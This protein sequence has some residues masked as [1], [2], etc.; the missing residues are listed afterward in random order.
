MGKLDNLKISPTMVMATV[1]QEELNKLFYLDPDYDAELEMLKYQYDHEE[2]VRMGL[3]A[4]SVTGAGNKYCYREQIVNILYKEYF[5]AGKKIPSMIKNAFEY[6][7]KLDRS[8]PIHLAR[9][10]EEGKSIGTKWQRLFIRGKLGIKEDMDVA[11]FDERYDLIYTPDAIVNING[12]KYAVEIKSMNKN[13]FENAKSHPSGQKQLKL[14][15]YLEGIEQGF[16]LADCK[17]NS[18][19]KIFPEVNVSRE[20]KH[21][22]KAVDLLEK[23]RRN[24]LKVLKKKK[25]PPCTCGKCYVG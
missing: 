23:T 6:R 4:S 3:H 7:S 1:I 21:I 12:K 15:M 2:V 18:Q 10:F 11:R 5:D 17:D 19:F 20:D 13:S 16:V 25:L 9:I 22:A 8:N 24:K 14:Y